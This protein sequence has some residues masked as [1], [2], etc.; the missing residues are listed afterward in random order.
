MVFVLCGYTFDLVVLIARIE[1]E[2][3]GLK[4]NEI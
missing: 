1:R 2:E 4:E 3:S